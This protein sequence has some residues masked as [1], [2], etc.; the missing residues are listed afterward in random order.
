M[1]QDVLSMSA[2][3]LDLGMDAC[4]VLALLDVR[5]PW[6]RELAVIPMSD[7]I[8]DLH[9]PMREVPSRLDEIRRV[10]NEV[11]GIVVY[12]HHGV[13]SMQVAEWLTEQGITNIANLRGGIEAWSIEVDPS[14]KR[15]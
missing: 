14:V 3:D 2:G 11:E 13:R 4:A 8:V 9:V 12:C 6:E 15:Y 5:E 7:Q 1:K 10:A